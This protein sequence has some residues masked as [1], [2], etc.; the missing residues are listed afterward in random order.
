MI[1]EDIPPAREA[2]VLPAVLRMRGEI[3]A[4]FARYVG[5]IAPDLCQE[6]FNHWRAEGQVGP[7]ALHRYIARLAHYIRE[8]AT[9]HAFV[10]E[11]T[12]RIHLQ[13][14]HKP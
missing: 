4:V 5:P 13:T 10:A 9:R 7:T 6:E 1:N 8:Q 12:H 14:I 2:R 11:A 3:D